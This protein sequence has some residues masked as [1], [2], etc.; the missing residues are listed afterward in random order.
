MRKERDALLDIAKGVGI[1]LVVYAHINKGMPS[2]V[3]YLFHM[4][5]FFML[6]GAALN[7]SNS[8]LITKK[9]K[10]LLQPYLLFSLISFFYWALLESR[11]RPVDSEPLFLGSLGNLNIKLQQ[12]INIFIAIDS[13][14]A[15]AYNVVMW[16]I[17]CLFVATAIYSLIKRI[18]YTLI[19]VIIII[20]LVLLLRE[21]FRYSLPWCLKR[22]LLYIPLIYIG[23]VSYNNF[24]DV[25]NLNNKILLVFVGVGVVILFRLLILL[26]NPTCGEPNTLV[27]FYLFACLGSV[28]V[29]ILSYMMTPIEH[30]VLQYLGRNSLIIMCIHEPIKRVVIVFMQ[31]IS[32]VNADIMR[33]DNLYCLICMILTVIICIPFIYI[34]NR[35][36]PF[37]IGKKMTKHS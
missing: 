23:E 30:N 7:Y 36:L 34:I 29:V 9:I 22:A 2:S 17:P 20:V 35:Y 24:K 25:F 26:F 28:F 8:F 1:L 37:L 14:K 18:G 11:F 5:L 16:F 10:S 21:Y 4:P 32:G 15:F 13:K 27:L 12:F 3:I 19:G 6:S 33:L 31:I